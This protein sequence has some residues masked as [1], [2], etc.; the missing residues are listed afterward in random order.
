MRQFLATV[1][2]ASLC[3]ATPSRAQTQDPSEMLPG[4]D[5]PSLQ[6]I[7]TDFGYRSA[8]R[9]FADG[10]QALNVLSPN[11]LR[12]IMLPSACGEGRCAAVRIIALFAA[13]EEPYRLDRLNAFNNTYAFIK[14]FK[15]GEDAAVSRY[16]TADYGLPKGNVV[17][18]VA[19]FETIARR[20]LPFIAPLDAPEEGAEKGPRVDASLNATDV[21]YEDD[22]MSGHAAQILSLFPD[23]QIDPTL[24]NGSP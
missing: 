22:Q 17:V 14:A 4:F 6:R 21:A 20:L 19:A 16:L 12:F 24:L 1:L 15:I 10:S 3:L 7:L 5:I 13:G 11:N 18:N 8:V 23:G 2:F 9:G